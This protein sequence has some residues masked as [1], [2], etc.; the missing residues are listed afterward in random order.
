[1]SVP[2]AVIFA[3]YAGGETLDR[4]AKG[5]N[6][7]ATALIELAAGEPLGLG[8]FA[9]ALRART[10]ANSAGLQVPEWVGLPVDEPW[11]WPPAADASSG[12]R[13]AGVGRFGLSG[14]GWLAAFWCGVGR[15]PDFGLYGRERV[16]RDNR[17]RPG[18]RVPARRAARLCGPIACVRGR[19]DLFDRTWCRVRWRNLSASGRLSLCRGLRR[20]AAGEACSAGARL[21]C[22]MS[23]A[24]HE[25]SALCRMPHTRARPRAGF[26]RR[27]PRRHTS[28]LNSIALAMVSARGRVLCCTPWPTTMPAPAPRPIC[29]K[30]ISEAAAPAILG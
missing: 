15:A 2:A 1:M 28:R 18:A 22:G 13:G 30:P 12:E 11:R 21:A 24:R 6:P 23:R 7:F 3:T 29:T 17:H 4:D 10:Q 16:R 5:G 20:R 14:G 19:G 25:S 8:T 26:Q 27:G 9:E